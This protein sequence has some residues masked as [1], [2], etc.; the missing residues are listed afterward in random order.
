MLHILKE[1]RFGLKQLG[2][3]NIFLVLNPLIQ[4][5]IKEDIK[6]KI[7]KSSKSFLGYGS[8]LTIT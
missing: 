7:P 4:H 5:I 6:H 3:S 1:K 8:K 2:F